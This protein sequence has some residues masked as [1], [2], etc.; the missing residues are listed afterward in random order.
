MIKL[1]VLYFKTC[2]GVEDPRHFKV[3]IAGLKTVRSRLASYQNAVG[4]VWEERFIRIWVG[5]EN[6]IRMAERAFKRSFRDQIT[7][8]EAGLSEWIC[9]VKLETLLDFI[10]ELRSE[11]YLKFNDVPECFEP[12]TMPLCED[13]QAWVESEYKE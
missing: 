5:A 7:S 2:P 8:S 10:N 1:Y 6:H 4:P 11:H 3:G 9:D 12:L 13:L